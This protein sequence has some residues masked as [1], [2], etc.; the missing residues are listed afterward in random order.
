M[1]RKAAVG[2]RKGNRTQPLAWGRKLLLQALSL[3]G[4]HAGTSGV[5]ADAISLH[6]LFIPSED[7]RIERLFGLV[8]RCTALIALAGVPTLAYAAP[9]TG[10]ARITALRPLSLVKTSDLDFGSVAAGVTPGT[11]VIDEDTGARTFTGGATGLGGTPARASFV[12]ASTLG[13]ALNI[14]LGASPTLLRS[15][16]GGSMTTLLQVQ[17][18]T[19]WRLFTGTGPHIFRVGGR[20]NVGASQPA[21]AYQGTFQLTVNYF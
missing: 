15:G 11:V 17:G 18:G 3:G 1:L 9:A 4:T 6:P 21:G 20:L 5:M 19:G 8:L 13:L 10:E 2:I 7:S 16:G 14:Q 12:G